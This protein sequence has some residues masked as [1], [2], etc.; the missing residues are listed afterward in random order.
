M[1]TEGEREGEGR[2]TGAGGDISD[3]SP[4]SGELTM[5]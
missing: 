3:Q 4:V 1:G 2:M 5:H